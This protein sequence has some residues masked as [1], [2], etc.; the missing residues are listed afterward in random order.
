MS[1]T[2]P[3]H[4]I[5][6]PQEHRPDRDETSKQSNAASTTALQAAALSK[7]STKETPFPFLDLPPE[8]REKIYV[9]LCTYPFPSPIPLSRYRPIDTDRGNIFGGP[10]DHQQ[11]PHSLILTCQQLYHEVRPIYWHINSFYLRLSR[12]TEMLDYFLTPAFQDNR[13]EVR[14]MRLAIRR[15][16]KG[17]F[18]VRVLAPVLE[19]MI[20]NG[21][22]RE[23]EV[24][25]EKDCLQ[26]LGDMGSRHG[27][28][29]NITGRRRT[30]AKPFQAVYRLKHVL[31]DPYLEKVVV[32][33]NR[34]FCSWRVDWGM[35]DQSFEDEDLVDA[36]YRFRGS[37]SMHTK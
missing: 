32:K 8:I 17:D 19:D 30:A 11:F 27:A 3:W 2:L 12:N 1:H 28:D 4:P 15:W 31:Q 14:S 23:I 22:L 29:D 20:L 24:W 26:R 16:G 25:L 9:L 21:R 10:N 36:T 34:E 5:S 7:P 33:T 18:F 37:N 13:R 6:W 35:T